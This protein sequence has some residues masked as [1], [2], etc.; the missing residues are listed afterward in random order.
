VWTE[1]LCKEQQKGYVKAN[2]KPIMPFPNKDPPKI[3][4]FKRN[5]SLK[6]LKQ[7]P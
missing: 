7:M 1:E 3:Y 6:D 2:A 5:K 4:S